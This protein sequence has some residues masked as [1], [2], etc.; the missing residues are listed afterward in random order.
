M[1][2][3]N[4]SSGIILICGIIVFGLFVLLSSYQSPR[5]ALSDLLAYSDNTERCMDRLHGHVLKT[6][7]N[8]NRGTSEKLDSSI[9]EQIETFC[10]KYTPAN[11]TLSTGDYSDL[12][13]L[14]KSIWDL[15]EGY[16]SMQ[17][18]A[19]G[20]EESLLSVVTE[21]EAIPK[22]YVDG[23]D[24][25]IAEHKKH[26][27]NNKNEFQELLEPI[28]R[29][30]RNIGVMPDEGFAGMVSSL[31]DEYYNQYLDHARNITQNISNNYLCNPFELGVCNCI[32]GYEWENPN[33]RTACIKKEETTESP[34]VIPV[35][36]LYNPF[37]D[38]AENNPNKDAI[39]YLYNHGII[40]G[41]ADGSFKPNNPVNRAELLKI[42]FEAKDI[43]PNQS[44]YNNC[45][46]DVQDQWFAK[47]VCRA[48]T[49]SWVEGYTDGSFKPAQTVNNAEAIKMLLESQDITVGTYVNNKFLEETGY[50]D[51]NADDWFAPYAYKAWE[52][53]ILEEENNFNPGAPKTRA[54][55][56]ENLY[57]LLLQED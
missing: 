4:H 37:N 41:Y 57:R 53:G 2:N 49:L 38:V 56:A 51:V 10:L 15:F 44:A 50:Y 31:L 19:I 23:L 25:D 29:S 16:A 39:L 11:S 32:E 34:E 12:T 22:W 5:V 27:L 45:F 1:K 48:K 43:S 54:S 55:I 24:E 7:P 47:Y 21:E 42:L 35:N 46:N 18:F 13:D 17:I 30:D 26:L 40:Q 20:I 28:I 9:E 33:F 14:G 52:L 3:K 36:N 6:F 8:Y